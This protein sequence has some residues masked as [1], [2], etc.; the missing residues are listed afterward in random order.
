MR[1][2]QTAGREIKRGEAFEIELNGKRVV[3]YDGETIGTVLLAENV[4]F[5][6]YTHRGAEP[7]WLFCGIGVCYDCL[8]TVNGVPNLRACMTQV[9]PRMRIQTQSGLGKLGEG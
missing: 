5:C 4:R 3:A 1:I 2:S 9:K 7:R 6:R 8:V